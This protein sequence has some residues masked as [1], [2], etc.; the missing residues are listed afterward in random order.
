MVQRRRLEGSLH[1]QPDQ[2]NSDLLAKGDLFQ[3]GNLAMTRPIAGTRAAS[4]RPRRPSQL[5][6][7]F[8][9]TPSYNGMTTS[10]LHADTFSILNT[11]KDP[12]EAFMALTALWLRTSC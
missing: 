5:T 4:T 9:V 2:I 12:E 6:C 3:S 10:K 11:T 8:A 1:P 7:G